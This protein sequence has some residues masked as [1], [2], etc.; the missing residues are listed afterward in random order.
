M[1][2]LMNTILITG[3]SGYL[4]AWI[5]IL[6]GILFSFFIKRR[7]RRFKGTVLGFIGGLMLAIVCFDLLPESFEAG[8]IY[9][10]TIGITFGLILAVLLDGKLEHD[11][12][13]TSDNKKHR[14]LKAGIFMAIGIGI[15][16]IPSG[17]ALGSL[18]STSSIKGLHLAI[19]LILHGI[20]EGLAVGIFFRESNLSTFSLVIISV[21]T[22]IPMGL[23]ALLGGIISKISPI[24]IC[25]S[26]AIAGG[27]ILYIVCRE[28]LP[29][30]RDTWKGRLSTIG[31][32]IGM[33][34]GILI[35]SFLD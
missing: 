24:V 13:P 34:A 26:L 16:N 27:M 29:N 21:I 25:I 14:F 8:S 4:T 11:K 32:V 2:K 10:A 19:A 9:I 5:G 3:V 31:N 7:G 35:V 15:H 28:T 6:T 20:P 30:A 22:S 23:G 1:S 12:I 17:I 33:I 18:L